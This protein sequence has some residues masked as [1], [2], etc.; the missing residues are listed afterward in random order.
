MS[1]GRGPH[2]SPVEVLGGSATLEVPLCMTGPLRVYTSTPRYLKAVSVLVKSTVGAAWHWTTL[3]CPAELAW[4]CQ[5]QLAASQIMLG[6]SLGAS[7]G[8]IPK[9]QLELGHPVVETK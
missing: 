1:T 7:T 2:C 4:F 8:T 9:R 5:D 6:H 3:V